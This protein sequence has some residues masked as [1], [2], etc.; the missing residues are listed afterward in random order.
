ML[1]V[2]KKRRIKKT[3]FGLQSQA[4]PAQFQKCQALQMF[5]VGHFGQ[6]LLQFHHIRKYL[7]NLKIKNEVPLFFICY[8]FQT[9]FQRFTLRCVVGHF[10]QILLRFHHTRKYLPNLEIKDEVPAVLKISNSISEVYPQCVVG[11]F[12]QILLRFHHI[13]RHFTELEIFWGRISVE[14]EKVTSKISV[15]ILS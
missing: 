1:T 15:G 14:K 6:I 11:H 7:T 10:C 2:C 8:K 5:C 13:R 12:C 9:Q 4:F 3:S